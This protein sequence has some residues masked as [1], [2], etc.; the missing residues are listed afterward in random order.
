MIDTPGWKCDSGLC[1]PTEWVCDK[2]YQCDSDNS[3]EEEGC[4]LYPETNCDSWEGQK[5]VQCPDSLECIRFINESQIEKECLKHRNNQEKDADT[6]FSNKQLSGED[7]KWKCTDGFPIDINLVC[8]GASDCDDSSDEMRG[9]S[10]KS[11]SE[12]AGL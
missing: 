3:D 5:Y 6:S 4:K 12:G 10:L 1:I 11:T 7:S 8:N 9:N 2:E